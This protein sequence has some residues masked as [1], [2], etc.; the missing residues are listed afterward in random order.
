MALDSV[1]VTTT[2]AVSSPQ[3]PAS[4]PRGKTVEQM[5]E[6][7][8]NP[9]V[10]EKLGAGVQTKVDAAVETAT[11]GLGDELS[12][13][14]VSHENMATEL[15]LLK[16]RLTK[17]ATAIEGDVLTRVHAN[18]KYEIALGFLAFGIVGAG[19]LIVLI[20]YLNGNHYAANIKDASAAV[21]LPLLWHLY[22]QWSAPKVA[23]PVAPLA[24]ALPVHAAAVNTVTSTTTSS[25]A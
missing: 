5:I 22:Q 19:G 20:Y 12:K 25:P 17:D 18:P 7:A 16:D 23:V 24:A 1:N 8:I 2:G 3:S 10:E 9:L 15:A 13:L 14:G 6:D 11:A 4:D 21:F